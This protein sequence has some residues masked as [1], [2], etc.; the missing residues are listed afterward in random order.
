MSRQTSDIARYYNPF[1]TDNTWVPETPLL[2]PNPYEPLPGGE[3][4]T[5]Q[6][7][8]TAHSYSAYATDT[9]GFG[10]Y[11]DFVAGVR[12]DRFSADYVQSIAVPGPLLDLEHTDNVTSPRAALLHQTDPAANLL[13]LLRHLLRSLRGGADVDHQ[14]GQPRPGESEE[15]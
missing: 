2:D 10:P 7:D 11:V 12:F 3:A 6:Q 15:L 5:S 8:T 9:L 13:C 14:N 4:I 1:N